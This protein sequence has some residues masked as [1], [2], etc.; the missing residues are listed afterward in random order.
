MRSFQAITYEVDDID[1]AVVELKAQIDTSLFMKNTCGVV[2]CGFEPD[3]AGFAY[4]EVSNFDEEEMER[5]MA[6]KIGREDLA[7]A[8]YQGPTDGH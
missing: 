7:H 2:F 3:I 1:I 5:R 6:E 8:I 4:H